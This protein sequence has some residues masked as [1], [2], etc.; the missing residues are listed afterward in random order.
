MDLTLKQKC[1][2]KG[3]TMITRLEKRKA[4]KSL[5]Q[6][7]NDYAEKGIYFICEID[8]VYNENESHILHDIQII[9]IYQDDE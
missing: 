1:G 9:D 5:K 2:R 8:D 3:L 6:F 7:L 4:I